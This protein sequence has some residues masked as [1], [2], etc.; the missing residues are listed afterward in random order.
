[1]KLK[2][3]IDT[4]EIE[5]E[6]SSGQIESFMKEYNFTYLEAVAYLYFFNN[7]HVVLQD[8]KKDCGK[9]MFKKHAKVLSMFLKDIE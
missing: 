6:Y 8:F 7:A 5:K 2:F 3:E 1:M 9:E 4:E